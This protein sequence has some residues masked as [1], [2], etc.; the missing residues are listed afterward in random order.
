MSAGLGALIHRMRPAEGNAE[1]ALVLFHGRGVDERDL[2][3]LLGE[4][5][6]SARLLGLAPRG[7][8]SFGP[9]GGSHW[10]AARQVGHP[11]HDTF[12]T[13]YELVAEWIDSLPGALGIPIE[14]IVLGGFSQGGV[15]AYALGLGRGRPRPAG[16]LALSCF[17]PSVDGFELNLD[18]LDGFPVSIA[19]GAHDPIIGVEF[20]REARKRLEAAG[21]AVSY[22]E[23]SITHGIDPAVVPALAGWLAALPG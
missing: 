14:R 22:H 20:G 16:I 10:Y 23:T 9:G 13:T 3:P 1:G 11:D 2:A 15:M 19:H 5:D 21:A 4:L 17:M 12:M 7:P 8:L 6:P 18:D